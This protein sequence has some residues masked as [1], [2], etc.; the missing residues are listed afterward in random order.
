MKPAWLNKKINLKSKKPEGLL[1]IKEVLEEAAKKAEVNYIAA[2]K[3]SLKIESTNLKKADQ[4]L[5]ELIKEIEHKSKKLG[6]EF[7]EKGKR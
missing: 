4:E 2:G 1:L 7:S 5:Q 3:Y 6:L